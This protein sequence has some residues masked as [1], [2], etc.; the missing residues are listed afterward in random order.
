M[1]KMCIFDVDGTLFDY[2]HHQILP[3]TVLALKKLQENG[4]KIAVAS[5]RVHYGLGKALNDLHFDYIC[6][7]NGGVICDKDQNIL[8][9]HDFSRED[10][11]KLNAFAHENEAGL[12]WKFIDHVYIYQHKEKID[13]YE[14]QIQSDIGKEPFIDCPS[15]DHH[16]VDFPQAACIHAPY[17]KVMEVFGDSDTMDFLRYSETGFDVVLKGI[18]KGSCVGELMKICN[19]NKDEIM[20]FGDNFNDLSMF[21]IASYRIAMGNAIDEIKEKATYITADCA[22]DGIYEACK[23]FHLI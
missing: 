5:G 14:S 6:A 1:I 16:L 3:S 4:I 11:D 2:Y 12:A 18:N 19:L 10:V 22:H 17:D 9:R 13:W 15:Q 21:E 7:V 8:T 23:H 20:V